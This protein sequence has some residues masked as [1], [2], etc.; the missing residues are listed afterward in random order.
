MRTTR[1]AR[2]IAATL[3]LAWP[4]LGGARDALKPASVLTWTQ[5]ERAQRFPHMERVFPH[6]PVAAG[7]HVH[8]L[9]KGRA[10]TVT[11]RKDGAPQSLDAFMAADF[12]EGLLVLQ[13]G[14]IRLERYGRHLRSTG[15]W[16]GFSVTKSITSTLYGAALKDG[17]IRSLDDKVTA[18]LPEMKGSAY[19]EVTLRQL[20]TM[21]SGVKWSEDYTDPASDVARMYGTPAD[22]GFDPI[23]SYMRKLP[24][25]APPGTKWSY[26]T[27]ETDLAGILLIRATGKPLATYLAE[28]IWRPYGMERGAVWMVNAQG[29]SPGGCCLSAALRDYARFGQFI[30][31]GG[32]IGKRAILPPDWL[33]LATSERIGIGRPGMGYGYFWWVNGDGTYDAR[34][35]FG[36]M[37]HIDPR[38]HLVVVALAAWPVAYDGPHAADHA[39]LVEAIAAA[40]DGE[41]EVVV[42]VEWWPPRARSIAVARI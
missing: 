35:I 14:R 12:T 5:G 40:V 25:E 23:V 19:D 20:L 28:K 39:R 38:R 33:A 17:A 34:G 2:L 9:P 1:R 7:G 27:G 10:L 42:D 18:Y 3:A 11:L 8:L 36:Q 21:S 13:D 26:K 4:A 15:H 31:D 32:R 30:L 16:P 24:R 6:R 41:G 37:I 29:Q 22:P